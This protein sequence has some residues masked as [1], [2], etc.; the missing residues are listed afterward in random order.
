MT[1]IRIEAEDMTLTTYRTESAASPP[2]ETH[3]SPPQQAP[4]AAPQL[5]LLG[6]SSYN[7]VLG[8]YDENDGVSHLKV[9]VGDVRLDKW[10]LNQN[11]GS[12]KASPENLVR[13]HHWGITQPRQL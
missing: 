12:A 5:R 7:V 2:A 4:W 11:L 1:P 8:Y 3:Q 10:S 13:S 6:G 9:S